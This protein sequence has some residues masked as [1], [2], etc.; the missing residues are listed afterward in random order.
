MCVVQAGERSSASGTHAA[1]AER[2]EIE[3][4]T[5]TLKLSKRDRQIVQLI[6]RGQPDKAIAVELGIGYGTVRT[7]SATA[8]SA[9]RDR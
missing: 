1:I 2:V 7:H 8:L 6:A 9:A 5:L 4:A 3:S